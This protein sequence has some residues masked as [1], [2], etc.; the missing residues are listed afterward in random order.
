M[1]FGSMKRIGV[2]TKMDMAGGSEFR[3]AEMASAISQI[4]GYQGVLLVEKKIPEKIKSAVSPTVEIHEG[5]FSRPNVDA[6][7]SVEHL[8]VINSDSRYFC[9][10]AYWLGL[11]PV[12]SHCVALSRIRQMTFLFNFIVSPACSLPSMQT[13]VSDIRIV[14]ANSKFFDE[15]SQQERYKGV[16]HYPRLQLESPISPKVALPKTHATR[17][18]FGMHSL[19]VA[20]KWNEEFPDLVCRVNELCR[21]RILWDF[22]GMP[23]NLRT[24][25]QGD[26]FVFR[27]EFSLPVG[28]YL[29]GIDV[30]VFFLS[31][32]REEP[33]SRSAGEALASGC[34]VITTSRGGN[35]N[36]VIHGNTGFLCKTLDE[37][38][39]SCAQLVE[40]PSLLAAM[41][42]NA[43]R[44]ARRFASETVAQRFLSFIQ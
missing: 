41:R 5:V 26:N 35:C 13:H 19:P 12:H 9:T 16:R 11:S 7:Y 44:S 25:C 15:I 30:F 2:F 14:T 42:C 4:D 40:Q 39:A 1:G 18:R 24:K 28:E 36:Q 27:P 38:A 6:L 21:D 3:A 20:G 43:A 31:W 29:A 33:W 23:A 10:E 32:K 17:L 8:L 22:M 37:F 34:P